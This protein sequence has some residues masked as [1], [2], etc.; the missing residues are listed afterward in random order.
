MDKC[1]TLC[2]WTVSCHVVDRYCFTVCGQ[3][4]FLIKW[5]N[6][7]SYHVDEQCFMSCGQA[8]FHVM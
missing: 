4:V 8:V 5:M 3:T 2:G 1:F 7:V 6:K